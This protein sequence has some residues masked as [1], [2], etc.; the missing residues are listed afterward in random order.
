MSGPVILLDFDGVLNDDAFL[1]AVAARHT[2]RDLHERPEVM[3]DPVRVARVQRLCDTT[4]ATVVTVTSWG[5]M[6]DGHKVKGALRGVGLTAPI[7]RVL[8]VHRR[9]FDMR[10]ERA[11][12]YVRIVGASRFVAIDDTIEHWCTRRRD[13]ESTPDAGW[14]TVEHEYEND[15]GERKRAVWFVPPW[16]AGRLVVPT[17]G[18]TD[19]DVT[20]ALRALEIDR[21]VSL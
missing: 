10:A 5:S 11:R 13:P 6:M 19:D 2:M 4:G 21:E 1:R 14:G 7:A 9:G 17:G 3:L 18:L 15:E 8:K 20:A 16:L 12:Q